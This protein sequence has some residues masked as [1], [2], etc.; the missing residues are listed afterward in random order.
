MNN[1]KS[2]SVDSVIRDV[3]LI[4]QN[5]GREDAGRFMDLYLLGLGRT[6]WVGVGEVYAAVK[7]ADERFSDLALD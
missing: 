2:R 4:M 3:L 1:L 7:E 6:G 5:L